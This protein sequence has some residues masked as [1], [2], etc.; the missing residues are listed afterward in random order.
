M[1]G[2]FCTACHSDP[3]RVKSYMLQFDNLT[4]ASYDTDCCVQNL[5]WG[6]F[7]FANLRYINITLDEWGLWTGDWLHPVDPQVHYCPYCA[8]ACPWSHA[9]EL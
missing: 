7:G 6:R 8:H 3:A 1:L 4:A 2:V 9:E 5:Q